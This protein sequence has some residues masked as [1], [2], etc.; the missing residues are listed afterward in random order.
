MKRLTI[1]LDLD[2]VLNNQ[3]EVW[4]STL[5]KKYGR[6]VAAKDITDW[7]MRLAFPG[8]SDKEIY[9]PAYNGELVR[10]MRAP[11]D[12]VAYTNIWYASGHELYV[13]TSTSAEN[14]EVKIQWLFKNYRWFDRDRFIMCHHKNLVFGDILVDDA[15][16]NLKDM[17][18]N[19]AN[20]R[21]V[22]VCMDRPWNRCTE[23]EFVRV[24]SF[25]DINSV[26]QQ[27]ENENA[28]V[29]HP[30]EEDAIEH[31]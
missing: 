20:H 8:L 25:A 17:K 27:L 9:G 4:V 30:K 18:W 5:N 7:D 19:G 1:L 13:V 10:N 3:N 2:D 12:A 22:C 16:H 29:Q 24:T 31:H 15:P 21:C 28:V 23:N 11:S 14:A 26:V 6:N